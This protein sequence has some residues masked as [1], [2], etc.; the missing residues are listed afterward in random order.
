MV[1]ADASNFAA[2]VTKQ[3]AYEQVLMQAEGLFVGQR[4]WVCN[5]ANV[6]ALL[7]HAYKSLDA[8]SNEVNWAGF[9]TL[10][11]SSE[12][13]Q[14][15]L[16]P[17]QGKVA[18]QTIEFGRGVCGAAAQ[19]QKTQLVGDVDKF[20]GHIACDG[21]SKSE[22]VVPILVEQPGE[23]GKKLVAII[24]IDC[25]VLNGFDEEDKRYLED[26]AALLAPLFEIPLRD[27][28]SSDETPTRD[29]SSRLQELP[30][31]PAV[32]AAIKA[33]A[34][35]HPLNGAHT[36]G[37][38]AAMSVDGPEIGTLVA[39][40]D[41]AKNL[42]NRKT[43]G[44]QDPYCAARLGKEAKKTTTDIRGG[45]TPKW[46]QELRFTVHDSPDYYQLKVSI[47]TDDKRTDLIGE[48][49]ID[50]RG[51]I[52]SGGGQRDIWQGLTCRGKYAG[53]IRIEI[54]FYD[55]RPKP[56][57]PLATKT[58]QASPTELDNGSVKQRTPVKRRPLPIDPVTGEAPPAP[59]AS[60]P[61]T[62]DQHM[63]PR[64]HSK[65]SSH[66]P[67]IPSQSPL[68][69]VE[70]NTPPPHASRNHVPDYQSPST[71]AG[72]SQEYATPPR[73]EGPRQPR[74][75]MDPYE[76]S[77]RHPEE[78]DSSSQFSQHQHEQMDSRGASYSSLP[79]AYEAAPMDDPRQY[80]PTEGD[81]PPPPPAHRSRH[82]SGGQELVPRNAHDVSPLKSSQLMR[83]DVLRNEAHRHSMPSYPGRPTFR[84]YDSAPPSQNP[85][86]PPSGMSYE[87]S[88]PRHH[89][90]DQSYDPHHRS[91]QPTVEDAPETPAQH[92]NTFRNSGQRKSHADQIAYDQVSY[93]QASSPAPLS[94]S[95]SPG[96][97]PYRDDPSPSQVQYGY[98]EHNPYQVAVSPLSAR[99]YSRSPGYHSQSQNSGH[100]AELDA[101]RIQ[102]SPNYT[103]PALPPS[104]I[105][106]LDPSLSQETSERIYEDRRHEQRYSTQ[107]VTTPTRGRERTDSYQSYG[108][109]Q[110]SSPQGYAPRSYDRRAITY[111]NGSEQPAEDT[112]AVSP[113]V[114]TSTSP[115]PQHT[116]RRKSVSPAPPPSETRRLSGVP[117]GPDSYNDLN[118]SLVSTKNGVSPPDYVD[119]DKKILDYDGREIDPSDH[120]PMDTWAPEPEP[121]NKQ[122]SPEPR[123]R[124]SLS[125]AQPMPPSTRRAP[126]NSRPH[127]TSL[128]L[129]SYVP[130]ENPR[131]PPAGRNRLQKRTS[132]V[133]AGTSPA[134][135][136]PLGPISPDN[137]QDRQSPYTPSRSL[138]R[139]ST[140]D[141][142]NENRAPYGSGP[143]IPAKIPLPIMSGAIGGSNELALLEEMQ[144]IDIG[145]RK[146]AALGPLQKRDTPRLSSAPQPRISYRRKKISQHSA[147]TS[148]DIPTETTTALSRPRSRTMAAQVGP[149]AQLKLP[150]GPSPVTAE[151]RYW[152]SFKN[153]LLIPSP[154]T[155]PVVHISSNSD[156]FA[157]TTGTRV[158]IYSN[159]TRKL[160]KTITRFGDVARSGEI[161]RDGRVLVAGD[162]TGKIQVFDVNS[163]AILKTWTT[164]K[165]PVWT[166]KFSPTDL[167]MLLSTSDDKTLRLWD[168]PSNEPVKTFVGHGDYVR[169]ATFMPGTMSNMIV[170]GSYD[171]TVKLWDPRTGSNSAVMTFK[172]A[173]PVEDV[174][175]MP[176]G[177]TILAAADNSISVL[178]LVAAR[179]LHMITN[180]QKTVTSLSLG[181]NGRRLVSA[182]LE[183]HV[184]VFETTGW[185]VVASTKYQSPVLSVKVIPS[186]DDA[187]S[188]DRHLA[189]GMQSGVLSIRTRLTGLEA[190]REAE[191]EKEM[192]ALL[193]GDID[194]HDAKK[195][196]RKRRVAAAKRLDL[197][198]EGP[199]VVIANEARTFKKKER[200]W[201]GLLRHARYGPAL[202]LVLDKQSPEH[203]PLNVLTLLL[204]L[205]HRSALH[206]A[207]ESRDEVSVQPI[208]KWVCG[209]ICDPRYVSVCVEVGLHLLDLYA[210]FVGGSAE[211]HE[212]FR[213]LHRRVK[214][215]VESAQVACQTGGNFRLSTRSH[216]PLLMG[217]VKTGPAEDVL[218]WYSTQRTLTVDIVGDFAGGEPFLV[219]GE[220]LIRHCLAQSKVDFHN[221][222]QLLHAV[223]AVE[224][225]LNNL[226]KRGCNFDIAFF[227]DLRDV[228]VPTGTADED[229]YKY[230]LA[231]TIIIRHLER[232]VDD[233]QVLEFDSY[234]SEAC[235]KYLSDYAIHFVLCHEGE[236]DD[237]G[238]HMVQLRHLI[239][240]CVD[241]GNNVAIINSMT[242]KSSKVFV[243]MLSGATGSLP[244]LD[245]DGQNGTSHE[246]SPALK[247]TIAKIGH[248]DT[249]NTD[250][251]LREWITVTF[252]HAI[253]EQQEDDVD[254]EVLE[255]LHALLLH[256]SA[257]KVCSL[258]ERQ[259]ES[260]LASDPE[261]A[262]EDKT[263]LRQ[264]SEIAQALLQS[265]DD[266]SVQLLEDDRDW[267]LYDLVDG[268]VFHALLEKVRAEKPFPED[269][270]EGARELWEE[271]I[272]ER[273]KLSE[274]DF[275]VTSEKTTQKPLKSQT[276]VKKP[277]VLAFDHPVFNEYLKAVQVDKAEETI[278]PVAK[279]IFEDLQHWKI[280]KPV[281]AWKKPAE[282]LDFKARR[283]HQRQMADIISYAASLSNARGKIL[284]R[285][286]IVV[287]SSQTFKPIRPAS[288][289][290]PEKEVK[291]KGGKKGIKKGGKESALKA[292]QEVQDRKARSKR[293]DVVRFWAEKCTEF[294]KD[295]SLVSR[296]LKGD[297]LLNTR[298]K[299]D[300]RTLGPEI[301]LYL[302]HV[303]G[304]IWVTTREGLDKSSPQGLYLVAM[305]WHWLREISKSDTCTPDI[306]KAVQGITT[307]LRMPNFEV[308]AEEPARGLPFTIDP[309]AARHAA[310]LVPDYRTL[311][312]EHGGPYMDRRFD[313]QPDSRVPFEPD[314]WQRNVLDS[315]D[316]N[317]ESIL[318]VAPTSAGKTFISF[319]AM[320][321]V[322]EESDD[323]VLVYVAPTK[324]L[325]NQIAAEIE[326]R[327]SKSYRGKVGKSVWATNTGDYK[328]NN[329][330][331]CQILV[332]VPHVLQI[333]LLDPANASTPTSWSRRVKRIIFDEVHCIGQADDGVIWEQLLLL[334]PCPVIALSATVGNPNEFRDWLALSQ[335]QKGYKM[336]MI[337][338]GVRYS[339]LR[340]FV[341]DAP[342][343]FAFK[344]LQKAPRLPVPGL[345]EGNVLSPNFKFVHP[346]VALKDRNRAAL[347]DVSLEAR[348]CFTL[349][350]KMD[351]TF[352]STLLSKEDALDPARALPEVISKSDIMAWEKRLKDKLRKAMEIPDSPFSKLQSIL[353]TAPQQPLS[354]NGETPKVHEVDH[355]DNLFS[356]AYELHSQ[357]ALP[358]IAFNYDR[359]ECEKAVKVILAR[360]EATENEWKDGDSSWQSKVQRFEQWKKL[361]EARDAKVSSRGKD[362]KNDEGAGSKLELA[363]EEGSADV[364]SWE[365]FD[366]D[367]PLDPY[368]FADA[369]KLQRS[370]F[371]V[372]VRTLK[373]HNVPQWLID[374]LLRGIGVH[375]AGLNRRYRQIVEILFRRGYLRFVVA[376]GT[377]AL[378]VNMPCKTVIF[379]GDSVFLTSQNYRQASGRAGRRGFDLL[380]NVVFNGIAR[381]RVH[382]IMSSRLPALKGQFPVSA[383]LVLRLLGLLHGTKNS[384]FA[385]DAVKAL[386]S[387]PRLYL[388]GPD[389]GTS[390]NHHLR[391]SI[392]YLRRQNL[393][394]AEGA[395]LN[396]AG[397]VGHLY[398]TENSVF[399]FHSLLRTGYFHELC[400]DI[401]KT[402][403][404]VLLEI[405]LVL[406]HLFNRI[407]VRRSKRFTDSVHRSASIVYLPPLPQG[408]EKKLGEH[409]RDTLS[410]FKSYVSSYV[411]QYL[412]DKPDQ[413][414]PLTK[415]AV[416]RQ[417]EA[418]GGFLGEK[419]TSIR[420]PFV[421]LSGFDDEFESIHELCSTVRG[422]VFLEESEVPY[423]P[424]RPHDSDMD[425][426]AYIYDF[427][428]HGSMEVLVRDNGIKGGEV[429]FHLK[430]F[431]ST[432]KTIVSSLKSFVSDDDGQD[433]DS[434]GSDDEEDDAAAADVPDAPK[435]AAATVTKAPVKTKKKVVVDSWD[436]DESDAA[437]SVASESEAESEAPSVAATNT[438]QTERGLMKV[439]KAFMLLQE[440]FDEKFFKVW[441]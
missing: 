271:I 345:D 11:K 252:S 149:L 218:A 302:C 272:D 172:H 289:A 162:D 14:L 170:S 275:N 381:D 210:E 432:L 249:K 114:R 36:A 250:L 413:T 108:H 352:P 320:K 406:C 319:Y 31:A 387:Q 339:D 371:D 80:P 128:S 416:G 146:K 199:D 111:N 155:Y 367:A 198:G 156:S 435:A 42:P 63:G 153:Q 216:L 251:S 15:I 440:Q 142:Q 109:G 224:D 151:Q 20:P 362:S 333:M 383:T 1:H 290:V 314:A 234:E 145:T 205:R 102:S 242:W 167:T 161:R 342:E 197:V 154:T 119:E 278:D 420:S 240:K 315:I 126:R 255:R 437:S 353:D 98:Q 87:P 368:S 219:H 43:I 245:F 295:P 23:S 439:L 407:P 50:L 67:F 334:A 18:C 285:E 100:Q 397:L 136:S 372:M 90:Y 70:Y 385:A 388:G 434:D 396:F 185:N 201:Q 238:P 65:Q 306:A 380:G 247:A 64:A 193:A 391:F 152:K 297:K 183:G 424:I 66:P 27:S 44:K 129:Q 143:P 305:M 68:Q 85:H 116:I 300:Y 60:A 173:A 303:L 125:G 235:Q 121:K 418:R 209:H 366:P 72:Q 187:D 38:F 332:T 322:L 34:Q 178:D 259:I 336:K 105:P 150:S 148:I 93:D 263:F 401:D 287:G 318:V 165:Q 77:P 211:L 184:K 188:M 356:L 71:H 180:H 190:G 417:G 248:Y 186:S 281:I 286:T 344:G 110:G 159:R 112:R 130:P 357:D 5:L 55:S 412:D 359:L 327:F 213:T 233:S 340:K 310:K 328:I 409:N 118:T 279:S 171:S 354:G 386:L 284:D 325:V 292:V 32:M 175:S 299:E 75:S 8:P 384:G 244:A 373:W 298:S 117:F 103:M 158:Q 194:S 348:D 230:Y 48:S 411:S 376:T 231:R 7:W 239:W 223:Y 390:V 311:Q 25:A 37:I 58:R 144:R 220:S 191:R 330:N 257:L 441:A 423:L 436:D 82:N 204:A 28:S 398:F 88:P 13:P 12:T 202:D 229:A 304:R 120:L 293:D 427:F 351:K 195:M 59:P 221:G 132:R 45:Q 431:S 140:W 62:P 253:L 192:A 377:L 346:V 196:K 268:R 76:L 277:A 360:L 29:S 131:T 3:D 177:T 393:L 307:A 274:D 17:F 410:I 163:R 358:A 309:K 256:T 222:F 349:W 41:R 169:C 232:A 400:A 291:Q 355:I 382:E 375:H 113:N 89:S 96:A 2:G 237:D 428:K 51:I 227:R 127:S 122:P 316:T 280:N 33:K 350:E 361:K 56:E 215:E 270:A 433:D 99:D 104:L 258:Q 16:G 52:V 389:S 421:A 46:D 369:S 39:I 200:P 107:M 106:G 83:H 301:G 265:S 415:T 57:K 10:N 174:L 9:Y 266:A 288:K 26:L 78:R 260:T 329:P 166:T 73:A 101:A 341:Y 405:L 374:G 425:F 246:T 294:E 176:S 429:W 49:W 141:H 228:C 261:T 164:H 426:N 157:V 402:P 276:T 241:G 217:S 269:I 203:S 47:F 138:P 79:E 206:E 212:G 408:A 91:M 84:G 317:N 343:Q 262:G 35:A 86:Q 168:L 414:L 24:D 422:G 378:G 137:Y 115:N 379:T 243:A 347:D 267:D 69:A 363:R 308:N 403:E 283:R 74:R 40:V 214:L 139:A 160:V 134:A 22:I 135:S 182:G 189:V 6:A 321:K 124:P 326:A 395:P 181:S 282:K 404:K 254:D 123:S 225:F 133:S 331:G 30:P 53:E 94:L 312:L 4:N 54:T 236:G 208:L 438:A 264:F 95:R 61:S 335:S 419:A 207:L 296:Y 430:D 324:A 97:S 147:G 364:S 19:S 337:V 179:P 392:E 92:P 81:R 273:E 394:S 323:A 226:Q 399:A 313:S 338:H 21:D 365:S 370:D